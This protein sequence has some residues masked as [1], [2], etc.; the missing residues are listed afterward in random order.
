M[1]VPVIQQDG[2]KNTQS[3]LAEN[4]L[5]SHRKTPVGLCLLLGHSSQILL[6]RLNAL[7]Q[8]RV[9]FFESVWNGRL[10]VRLCC[11]EFFHLHKLCQIAWNASNVQGQLSERHG[12][13]MG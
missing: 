10:E 5:P 12:F 1:M 6:R 13:G 3:R 11:V 4:L 2:P 7:V 9:N 8:S